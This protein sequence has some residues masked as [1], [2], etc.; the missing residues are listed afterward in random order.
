MA[1]SPRLARFLLAGVAPAPAG[2]MQDE[3]GMS[4]DCGCGKADRYVS[5]RGIDCAGNAAALMARLD[6]QLALPG[7]ADRFWDY[8][9]RKR[10]GG[11]GPRPDDLFL[12]HAHINQ[13]REFFETWAD[14]EALALLLR[15]EEECC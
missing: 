2:K 5:F 4:K 10:E 15:I 13:I 1:G 7:R 11:S 12:I 14:A 8:F 9:A 3:D 6:H